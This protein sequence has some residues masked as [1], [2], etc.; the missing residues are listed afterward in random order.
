[1]TASRILAWVGGVIAA[2][3]LLVALLMVGLNTAPGKQFLLQQL[4][5]FTTAT[6]LNY[7]A[8]DIDGSIYGRMTIRDL[9]VRDLRG[10]LVTSPAVVVD[11]TPGALLDGGRIVLAEA[12]AETVRL[13]RSPEMTPSD[14]DEPLLPDLDIDIA[15]FRVG[16]FIIEPPLTGRR[17]IVG[18]KGSASIADGRATV[19]LDAAARRGVG[20]AGGD[21]LVLRLDAVPEANRLDINA[22]LAAP[23][24]GLVDGFTRL[25]RP[26]AA[27]ISGKGSWKDWRGA[28][29][30]SSGTASLA[31]LAITAADGVF[32]VRGR[33][34]P[35]VLLTGPAQALLRQVDVDITAKL[36][37]RRVDL[38]ANATSDAF[39]V[40]AKGLVDLGASRFE[41]FAVNAQLLRPGAIAPDL[42]G[43][44]VRLAA[45]IDGA[46]GTPTLAYR[47]SAA[48]LTFDT[49]TVE[50]LV[51]SGK[52]T[53]DAERILVPISA[54]ARRV[55]GLNA[56]AGGLLTNLA[57]D[58]D[59]AWAKGQLLSDNLRLRSDRI[60]AT[61]IIIADVAK[62]RYA[63][64]LKGR[65]NDYQVAGLGRIDVVTDARLITTPSDGFG[66]AGTAQ[67]AT[68]RIDNEA[69]R[70]Q[71]GGNAVVTAAFGY[72]PAGAA[73]LRNLRMTAPLLRIT[74]G[75]GSYRTDTG[76]FTVAAR[77]VSNTYG[78]ASVT[79]SGTVERP[80]VTVRADR[81]G[82]GIDVRN[83]VA[84][85]TGSPAGYR[86]VA[87]GASAYGPLSGDM[88]VR[89]GKALVIDINRARIA[90]IDARGRVA[91]TVAGPFAGN[92]T[93]AGSGITGSVRLAAAGNVQR[94]DV[95]AR[96]SAARIP[97][98][99][100]ITIGSG[101]ARA[102][103][104][105]YPDA[106]S[107]TGT[108]DLADVRSGTLLV[109]RARSRF[110]Y[111]GGN[112][113]VGLVANGSTTAPFN[114]A[115]QARLTP[116]QVV[117]NATGAFNGIS[118]KLAAPAVATKT[119]GEWR[120]APATI[121]FPQGRAR[122]AG[123]Y[124][125]QARLN[126][127]LDS[128][129]LGIVNSFVP[130]LG[131]GG[132]ASGTIDAVLADV[133]VVDARINVAGFTRTA[134]YTISAPVDIAT[135]AQLSGS[136]GSIAGAIRRGSTTIGRLQARVAP[137]P[138]GNGIAA[139]L[140]AAP[141]SGGIR[142]G[143]PAEVLWALTGIAGQDV[144]GPISIAADFGGRVDQPR[145]TGTIRA[146]SLRYANQAY[147]TVI[148]DIAIQGNFTQ[149][150]LQLN[151]LTA[152]AGD[153]TI[154]ASGFV[155][156][157]AASGFPANIDVRFDRAELA[158]GDAL[159]AQAT[160][161]LTIVNG[162]GGALVSGTIDIP[163]ARY[164]II[165]QGD[166]A[167]TLLTGV[168]RKNVPLVEVVA[169]APPPG[170]AT[171]RLD[172][173]VRADNR[174]FVS[175]MGLEAEWETDMRITG[176]A[177]AP[178]IVGRLEVVRGTYSFAGRRFELGQSGAIVFDGGQ[179]TNPELSLSAVTTVEGVTATI[180]IGGRAQRP[181]ITFTS[182]PT[183]PQDEVLSRLLFGASVT[184]ISPIQ[185]VQLAAA[186][187][188]LRGSGGGLN[189][190]GKLRS[191]TGIDRLRVLGEDKT[192]GRG[193]S[194]AAGQYIASNIYVEVIT[195]ARGFT[196][197]QLEIGLTRTLSLLSSTGSFGGSNVTLRY[198]RDY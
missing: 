1:M 185:A 53:V 38:S 28:L 90:G 161:R 126:A 17:H 9:E 151:S 42:R 63:G 134:A 158:R 37:E 193:T 184:N 47:V 164:E 137:L 173:R 159:G 39:A 19:A 188:S 118:F 174:I 144:T 171:V 46:F 40:N 103:I 110:D 44:D 10:V 48:S 106:P 109:A 31:N 176:T 7:R 142:Y 32:T 198:S 45:T 143:G 135:S 20:I 180:N 91:Q 104:I 87:S 154:A 23:V 150:Q 24:G 52:A 4:A 57:I 156:L 115:A 168:R 195:D 114:V 8:A 100:P 133:P 73:T 149:S 49:T 16:S 166:S 119:G 12:S 56:A 69:V 97:G 71:L 147:G 68:R 51:A 41:D 170:P 81:P 152:R 183:L 84:E 76:R 112:G 62:G 72:D 64:T 145:L 82:L 26:L 59:L 58:G 162:R 83:L 194:V 80:V 34:D 29:A 27:R 30:A 36:A 67:I 22:R 98:N 125:K 11:W 139:R 43:N 130:D 55:T 96:A 13:L 111:R 99:V 60:D 3:V 70:A 121:V 85:L 117:A 123:S 108:A 186:L 187:N 105:L 89:T 79:G 94:A 190:L 155:G 25:G 192:T 169:S 182:T 54:R 122:I 93:L 160:G 107:I 197:T 77:A 181:Q 102:A 101:T 2:I 172:V 95:D 78:P 5:G 167:V 65:F 153:G 75:S 148:R 74:D 140:L 141:L 21:A 15:S 124:G 50:G 128:V 165:R 6:G 120:L 14:P 157:D 177:A 113:N 66:I 179:F 196:A 136:G 61:A 163:E 131:L 191:A 33:T 146:T 127:V 92:I 138:A 189:P 18:L 178:R 132:K 35:G 88:L 175:G 86:I 116:Q 129:D